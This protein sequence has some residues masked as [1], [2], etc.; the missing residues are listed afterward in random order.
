MELKYIGKGNFI[1]DVPARD[2]TKSEAE[3]FGVD[4]LLSSGLYIP[5]VIVTPQKSKRLE[6]ADS[7]D[8][9]K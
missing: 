3:S 6:A 5:A 8:G 9:G 2:L 4:R 7:A 1:P